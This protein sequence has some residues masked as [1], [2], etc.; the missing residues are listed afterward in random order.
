MTQ[1]AKHGMKND[2]NFIMIFN[3]MFNEVQA[4]V[5]SGQNY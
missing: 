3:E 5:Q 1:N 4:S 2:F